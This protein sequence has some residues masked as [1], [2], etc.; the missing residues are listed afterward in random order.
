MD[1]QYPKY[2]YTIS[3]KKIVLPLDAA[4][5]NMAISNFPLFPTQN[6][7]PWICPSVKCI[8]VICWS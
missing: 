1:N 6:H 8:Y 7:I 2:T 5:L 4:N 3:R